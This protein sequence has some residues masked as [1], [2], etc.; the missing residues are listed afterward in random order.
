VFALIVTSNALMLARHQHAQPSST[1]TFTQDPQLIAYQ[2]RIQTTHHIRAPTLRRTLHTV[3]LEYHSTMSATH[4]VFATTE[5]LEAI[6]L[7][8]P[9]RDLLQFQR[10]ARQWYAVIKTSKK[11][12]RALFLLLG[13][14]KPLPHLELPDQ[15]MNVLIIIDLDKSWRTGERDETEHAVFVNPFRSRIL[16]PYKTHR[17]LHV[18]N[19]DAVL[20]FKEIK[21]KGGGSWEMMQVTSP[22]V[23]RLDLEIMSQG[24]ELRSENHVVSDQGKGGVT[25]GK[26]VR[27]VRAVVGPRCKHAMLDI[28]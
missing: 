5:L 23:A 22:P 17:W 21:H 27:S 11:L 18:E 8:F 4:R 10:V 19:N 14:G 13:P 1:T 9:M 28:E 26:L 16:Q 6:L 15:D 3:S 24:N 25:I 2:K 12:Q 20:S 7:H